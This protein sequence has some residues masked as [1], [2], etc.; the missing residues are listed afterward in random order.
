MQVDELAADLD[1]VRAPTRPPVDALAADL[2]AVRAAPADPLATDLATV[3]TSAFSP[4]AIRPLPSHGGTPAPAPVR[5][6]VMAADGFTDPASVKITTPPPTVPHPEAT[7]GPEPLP[8]NPY[9]IDTSPLTNIV[10]AAAPLVKGALDLSGPANQPDARVPRGRFTGLLGAPTPVPPATKNAVSTILENVGRAAEPLVTFAAGVAP[11]STAAGLAATAGASH[12]VEQGVT[13]V[14]GSPEDARLAGNVAGALVGAVAATKVHEAITRGG[15]AA[16]AAAGPP[17]A[18][19]G[20]EN[21]VPVGAGRTE[22]ASPGGLPEPRAG[23]PPAPEPPVPSSQVPQPA[24]VAPVGESPAAPS[25]VPTAAIVAELA[26]LNPGDTAGYHAIQTALAELERRGISAD[27]AQQLVAEHQ[28]RPPATPAPDELAADLEQVRQPDV[29]DRINGKVANGETPGTPEARAAYE[30]QQRVNRVRET[31]AA[32]GTVTLYRGEGPDGSDIGGRNFTTSREQAERYAG[33]GGRVVS[34]EVDR[35]YLHENEPP[36]SAHDGTYRVSDELARAAKPVAGELGRAAAAPSADTLEGDLAQVREQ[37]PAEQPTKHKFASTQV[38]LPAELAGELRAMGQSIPAGDLAPDAREAEPH[39]TVKFGLHDNDPEAV[40]RVLA[41]EPPITVRLGK[42]SFFPNGES[43]AGDVLKVDIDSP[44]LHR[45]NKKIADALPHTDTHPDYVP[46]A[47]IAYL[48]PGLGKQY[49]NDDRLAGKTVTIDRVTFTGQNDERVEIPLT[50]TTAAAPKAGAPTQAK[51][52]AAARAAIIKALRGQDGPALFKEITGKEKGGFTPHQLASTLERGGSKWAEQAL[53]VGRRLVAALEAPA[54]GGSQTVKTSPEPAVGDTV[55][56]K[57]GRIGIVQEVITA[58]KPG[59]KGLHAQRRRARVQFEA[60]AKDIKRRENRDTDSWLT[61]IGQKYEQH[62]DLDQIALVEGVTLGAPTHDVPTPSAGAGTETLRPGDEPADGGADSGPPRQS[63][64]ERRAEL[65]RHARERAAEYQADLAG[66]EDQA[67]DHLVARATAGGFTGDP[68]ALRAELKDRLALL[69]ELDAE[70]AASGHNPKALLEAIVKRGGLSIRKETALQGELRWLS[71]HAAGA[72]GGTGRAAAFGRVGGVSGVFNQ[73]GLPPDEMLTSLHQEE[74]FHYIET[75]ADFIDEL[76]AAASADNDPRILEDRFVAGLGPRW[77]EHMQP[78][79]AADDAVDTGDGDVSF[80]PDEL[81][82]APPSADTLDT[83]EAQTRLPGAEAARQA[84]KANTTFR[85][86]VQAT[87]DDFAQ[88]FLREHDEPEPTTGTLFSRSMTDESPRPRK[89]GPP[90]SP[91]SP[92]PPIAQGN[93]VP[94]VQPFL[95]RDVIPTLAEMADQA[96]QVRGDLVALFSP[97]SVGPAAARGAAVLRSQLAARSQRQ[98]RAQKI[99]ADLEKAFDRAPRSLQIAFAQAVD[100]GDIQR[101]K[102]QVVTI[103]KGLPLRRQTELLSLIEVAK[104]LNTVTNKKRDETMRRGILKTYL[105]HYFPREWVQPGRVRELV[106]RILYRRR[107]LQG[108]KAFTKRRSVNEDTGKQFTFAEMLDR[109]FEPVSWNPVTAYLR[110]WIEMDKAIVGH[111]IL[112]E[113][114]RRKLARLVPAGKLAPK[115]WIRFDESFGAVYG[116]P[117]I[118]T[119]EGY[120]EQLMGALDRFARDLGVTH[121]RA[122][123]IGHAPAWGWAR[124]T[125]EM[126]SKAFGPETVIMHELGHILDNRY[127]FWQI[128]VSPASRAPYTFKKGKKKG[129][130]VVRA[131]KED[132]ATKKR[133][134]TVKKEL[135]ALADLRY[136]GHED[137]VSEY[138]KQYVREQPEQMAN[139]VHAFIW[140]PDRAKVLAP[141]AYWALFNLTKAHP[142]LAPL[143]ELQQIRSLVLGTREHKVD[144]AGPTVIGHYYGPREVVRLLHNHL[145]PGLRGKFAFDT[146][147]R[148]GNLMNQVQLGFSAF[149]LTM[150]GLET[151]VSKQ[152]QTLQLLS[153][154][155]LGAAAQHQLEVPVAWATDFWRGHQALKAFY[156][157]DATAQTLTDTLDQIIAAGGGVGWDKFQ[158]DDAPAHVM[159]AIRATVAEAKA[160]NYPGAAARSAAAAFW[161]VPAV[162]EMAMKPIMEGFVPRVKL[163]AFLDHAAMEL[164][165]LGP[166]PSLPEVQRVLGQLWDSMDNRFGQLRYDNLFWHNVLKDASMASVRAVGWNV[167]TL[168]EVYGAPGAQLAN[169]GLLP[170]AAGGGGGGRRPTRLV[171]TGIGPEGEPKYEHVPEPWLHRKFAYVIAMFF[172]VAVAGALLQYAMTGQPPASIRDLYFPRTGRRRP[173]GTEERKSIPSYVKDVYHGLRD[174]PGSFFEMLIDKEHPALDLLQRTLEN[175]DFFGVEIRNEKDPWTEQ[176]RQVFDYMLTQWKPMTVSNLQ[177]TSRTFGAIRPT[178]VALQL[179]GIT[180]APATVSRSEAEAVLHKLQKR[181]G[182]STL[183]Q[184]QGASRDARRE[185]RR[186]TQRSPAVGVQTAREAVAEG[187]LR[188]R[189]AEQAVKQAGLTYLQRGVRSLALEDALDVYDVATPAERASLQA[190]LSTKIQNADAPPTK[191]AAL[192]ERIHRAVKLPAT[193]AAAPVAA[194]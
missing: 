123:K 53:I 65:R 14:G 118:M 180:D 63:E 144:L 10:R 7:I 152:A 29:V 146:Y 188:P 143:R 58:G 32:A 136:E 138:Y 169:L 3:Q 88:E 127:G 177:R 103:T 182:L 105:Q 69:R 34:I 161:S 106:Q 60:T 172:I 171:N 162:I 189:Q 176:A 125:N 174:V 184:E 96:Y 92:R 121:T 163:G 117:F 21:A 86:P 109:G 62:V 89:P 135:R 139:L 61:K 107:P 5:P 168:R 114:K 66:A 155:Q 191:R 183:T 112:E 93:V 151:V 165:T 31:A 122:A 124:G 130:T 98:Q 179:V 100:E 128:V 181:R 157:R 75:L 73:A 6:P 2:E 187:T 27:Q 160:G 23:L 24:G 9:A 170:G 45:L 154:G 141:T 22:A 80:N 95:E 33:P 186:D 67:L 83:G 145:S 82:A 101:L 51:P 36:D 64:A 25:E 42:T 194:R 132:A 104:T 43:N 46:H 59:G 19:S 131:V 15:A 39:V 1:A 133:R 167:G 78:P 40:R 166:E 76:Q 150:I 87:G 115:D 156:A 56:L 48:K 26:T 94:G 35:A 173:D 175:E 111:D 113:L 20:P 49:A 72:G 70:F 142:E 129:Q 54:P 18:P 12:A 91:K 97:S 30:E 52:D 17:N 71:E 126:A 47:T 85:A 159:Q 90:V 147:R 84:G 102:G 44:D 116:P 140:N 110:K 37:P 74:R 134:A 148:F 81:E 55:H 4:A 99:F 164:G 149:H 158:H 11:I 77:W 28:A 57:D 193:K 192:L 50:G 178:D 8:P 190:I 137:A 153:R 13:A 38:N 79:A 119:P 16:R 41:G 185:V 108:S 120:D 68:V